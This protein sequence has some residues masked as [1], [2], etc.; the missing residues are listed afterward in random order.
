M[1]DLLVSPA[2]L[3]ARL[4]E[5]Q[6]VDAAWYMPA[7]PR[8]G[9]QD[10]VEGHIAGAIFFDID[11]IAD[12]TSG[13]PHMLPAPEDFAR[14]AGALGLRRDTTVVV[15]DQDLFSAPRVWWTLRIMGFPDVRVLDGGLKA[16][17]VEGRPLVATPDHLPP[18]QLEPI[19]DAALVRDLDAVAATLKAGD[20][21]VIDARPAA[22]FTG[23]APEP[24]EGLR[25]GHMPGALSLPFASLIEDGRLKPE[26]ELRA[27][28][29]AAGVDLDRPIVTTCGSGVSAAV[30]ALAFATLGRDD[31]AVYDGS[32][33]EWGGRADTAVVTG[34]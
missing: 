21:Q 1:R 16:W 19:F 7:D 18:S 12:H 31:V 24:R 22:R 2:W 13:L 3:E 20:A 14:R 26:N 30:L 27:A 34:A 9:K 6:V 29:A 4:G 5:V 28:F 32:W 11:A 8:N 10:H 17:R 33:T 25:G 15:Y 23:E